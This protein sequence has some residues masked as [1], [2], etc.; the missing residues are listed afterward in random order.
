MEG[1]FKNDKQTP[2]FVKF[3]LNMRERQNKIDILQFVKRIPMGL[4]LSPKQFKEYCRLFL[5]QPNNRVSK[6]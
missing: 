3:P 6:L 5:N 2:E 1:I 4:S